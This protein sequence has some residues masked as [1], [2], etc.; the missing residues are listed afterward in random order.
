MSF[1]RCSE[2][3]I[4]LPPMAEQKRIADILDKA[5]AIRRKR[6]KVSSSF[7]GLMESIFDEM[8]GPPITNPRGW[9]VKA[10]GRRNR[11][12]HFG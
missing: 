12:W 7:R 9:A 11:L 2:L 6:Q 8:F 1:E 4:P 5:D 10:N 3:E